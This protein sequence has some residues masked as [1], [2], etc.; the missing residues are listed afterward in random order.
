[1]KTIPLTQGKVALVDDEDYDFLMQWKWFFH[2]RYAVRSKNNRHIYMHRVIAK[3]PDGIQTDHVNGDQL[4]NRRSNL[5][6]ANHNENLFN[7][8]KQK[9]KCLSKY[10]GVTRFSPSERWCA[11]ISYYGKLRHLGYFDSEIKAA[12]AYNAE[13]I[14]LFGEFAKINVI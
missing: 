3:T 7:Q 9:R 6:H 10:K 14:K 8:R 4:D 13:A 11:R 12:Q 2:K 5:R 1:V